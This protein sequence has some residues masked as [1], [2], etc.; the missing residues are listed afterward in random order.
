MRE[1]RRQAPRTL[2]FRRG[3]THR[4][5]AVDRTDPLGKAD[6]VRAIVARGYQC[7]LHRSVHKPISDTKPVAK[8]KRVLGDQGR[9]RLEMPGDDLAIRRHVIECGDLVMSG[10]AEELAKSDAVREAY[11]GG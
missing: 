9:H 4:L 7:H 5:N 8:T 11:L 10:P 2:A 1:C 3:T 6:V